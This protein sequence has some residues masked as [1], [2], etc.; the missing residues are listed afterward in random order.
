ML[1]QIFI[2]LCCVDGVN[3]QITKWYNVSNLVLYIVGSIGLILVLLLVVYWEVHNRIRRDAAVKHLRRVISLF[4][5]VPYSV[6]EGI[7]FTDGTCRV[8]LSEFEQTEYVL[9]LPCSHI[10]HHDC[11]Y[12]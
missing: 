2:V 1:K 11:I 8:C 4:L 3:A 6:Q 7:H 9:V 5:R 12:R 10:Y